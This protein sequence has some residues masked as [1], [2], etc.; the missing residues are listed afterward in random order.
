MFYPSTPLWRTNERCPRAIEREALTRM[1]HGT[2]RKE[3]KKGAPRVDNSSTRANEIDERGNIR[4]RALIIIALIC[5]QVQCVV[6]GY[7]PPVF[8]AILIIFR[9]IKRIY[10]IMRCVKTTL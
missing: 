7:L 3:K 9:K 2:P 1:A 5:Y 8:I 4:I 10:V 6:P